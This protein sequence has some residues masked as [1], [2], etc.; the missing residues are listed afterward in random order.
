MRTSTLLQVGSSSILRVFSLIN[1]FIAG[2]SKQ[3]NPNDSNMV[4]VSLYPYLGDLIDY[5]ASFM[6]TA[7]ILSIIFILYIS[8]KIYNLL[9]VSHAFRK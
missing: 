4:R 7:V 3:V 8:Q 9:E 1:I 2:P 5:C 6:Q